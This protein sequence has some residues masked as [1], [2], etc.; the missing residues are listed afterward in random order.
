LLK[1]REKKEK[2]WRKT[3]LEAEWKREEGHERN[4]EM[5]ESVEQGEVYFPLRIKILI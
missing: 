1:I 3:L 5:Y 4:H 2:W